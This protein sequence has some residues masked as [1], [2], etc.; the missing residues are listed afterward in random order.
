M[1]VREGLLGRGLKKGGEES[2][3]TKNYY[4]TITPCYQSECG[5]HVTRPQ[6]TITPITKLAREFFR[7]ERVQS[8]SSA[9]MT[10]L[11]LCTVVFAPSITPS[12][13]CSTFS[14]GAGAGAAGFGGLPLFF[15]AAGGGVAAGSD[16]SGGG[17]RG[18]GAEA[19]AAAADA[20]DD[21]ELEE[22]GGGGLR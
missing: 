9:T 18:A 2:R 8:S 1:L 3:L 11:F 22:E 5:V 4:I 14:F 10:F 15:A 19:T 13:F 17:G 20:D 16:S 12:F 6:K 21:D 7:L